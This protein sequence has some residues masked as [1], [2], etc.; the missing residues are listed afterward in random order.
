MKLMAD[1]AS[2]SGAL[3]DEPIL[4]ARARAAG[5]DVDALPYLTR[6]LRLRDFRTPEE[7]EALAAKHRAEMEEDLRL[8]NERFEKYGIWNAK[9]R[10]W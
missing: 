3:P 8:Y 1:D 6:R 10:G 9:L 2:K 4:I 5:I 7:A